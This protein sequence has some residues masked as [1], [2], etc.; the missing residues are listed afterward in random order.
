M[1]NW[2]RA[3]YRTAPDARANN[4]APALHRLPKRIQHS[5]FE[6]RRLV[7]EQHPAVGETDAAGPDLRRPAAD[8]RGQR[9]RMMRIDERRPGDQRGVVV[10]HP[11]HRMHRR[12]LERLLVVQRRQH[13]RQPRRQHR[14]SGP[15]RADHRQVMT[16]GRRELQRQPRLRLT[17]H[18]RQIRTRPDPA[19]AGRDTRDQRL[20]LALQAGRSD[21][22]GSPPPTPTSR[23]P[24]P[25]RTDS[26][27]ARSPAPDPT[28]RPPATPATPRAPAAPARPTPTPRSAPCPPPRAAGTT[29][30]AA[31]TATAKAMS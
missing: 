26:R 9:R 28:A 30:A 1:I 23:S 7:Q 2:N 21:R 31:R 22:A 16:T 19:P 24:T 27:P 13:P 25:P 12:H 10:Q 3:G 5:R 4:T 8:H 20:H 29:P 18:V 17:Q 11:G 14:L 6:L 15:G